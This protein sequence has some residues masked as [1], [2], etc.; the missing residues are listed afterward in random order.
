MTPGESHIE[1]YQYYCSNIYVFKE[2][3][4]NVVRV[5]FGC[6]LAFMCVYFMSLPNGAMGCSSCDL[7]LFLVILNLF[8]INL[9]Q[10]CTS[11]TGSKIHKCA[12]GWSA[13]CECGFS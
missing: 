7:L 9:N 12:M 11:H 1:W 2:K 13:I 8:F 10:I 5:G 3:K 6:V 4:Y